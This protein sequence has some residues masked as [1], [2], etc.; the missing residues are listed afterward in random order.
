MRYWIN[1]IIIALLFISCGENGST[2]KP[3]IFPKVEYPSGEYEQFIKSD[4]PFTFQMPA[5]VSIEQDSKYAKFKPLHPC[6][7]N[8]NYEMFQAQI[9]CSYAPISSRKDFEKLRK[10]AFEIIDQI[11]KR[12]D[13]MEEYRYSNRYGTGG[14]V[15]DFEGPAASPIH[16]FLTDTTEHFFKASLYYNTQVRPDSLAPITK[17]IKED[18]DKMLG[19]FRWTE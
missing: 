13:Y 14:I 15:F 5:Y 8:L 6:W 7:F 10:D 11:N 19:T 9:Y 17:F 16:F 3:R 12:S 4:C 1:L 18:I 2:P